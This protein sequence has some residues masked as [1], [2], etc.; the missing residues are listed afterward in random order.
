[1]GAF[2]LSA[3]KWCCCTELIRYF[4]LLNVGMRFF[5]SDALACIVETINSTIS[6]ALSVDNIL[7]SCGIACSSDVKAS[8]TPQRGSLN[9]RAVHVTKKLFF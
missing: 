4:L 1:M 2:L 6:F 9:A 5:F 7:V 8:C 3:Y